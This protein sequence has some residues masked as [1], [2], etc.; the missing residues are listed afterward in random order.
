MDQTISAGE[1]AEVAI[2]SV[3][4]GGNGVGRVGPVV[5]FV[6]FTAPG[7]VIEVRIVMVKKNYLI[8]EIIRIIS[9]SADRT[10]PDCLYFSRCGGCQYQHLTYEAQLRIKERQVAETFERIGKVTAPPVGS[11]IPSPRPFGYRGKAEFHGISVGGKGRLG[12][13]DTVGGEVVDIDHCAIVDESINS[14]LARLRE[15]LGTGKPLTHRTRYIMWSG[16]PYPPGRLVTRRVGKIDLTVPS[17][18]FF[19]GNLSLTE[20]LVERAVE[21]CALEGS[22]R[23]LDA[24]CGSGLFSLFLAPRVREVTGVEISGPAVRCAEQ[25]AQ[26]HHITN[27]RFIQ[28]DLDVVLTGM[29]GEGAQYDTVLLDPPR[30]GC[31]PATLAAIARLRPG[32]IVYVSC[33]PATQARDVGRLV[34][35]GFSLKALLPI[36]MFPQTQHIEVIALLVR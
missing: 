28:G 9:P 10:E 7:D 30:T 4:F 6:P 21:L 23:V 29:A 20:T 14:E 27:A 35:G 1:I 15:R 17:G 26:R 12:F 18:G 36:D 34:D 32:R 2:E 19:Q 13:M 25:N 5:I 33:N 31:T 8:G 3:A 24:C 16:Y 22:D 11:I